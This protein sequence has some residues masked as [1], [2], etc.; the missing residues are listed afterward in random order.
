LWS[1]IIN[2]TEDQLKQL[3]AVCESEDEEE[4]DVDE[5]LLEHLSSEERPPE[6]G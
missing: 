5:A 1:Y 3:T 6:C 2:L 4:K